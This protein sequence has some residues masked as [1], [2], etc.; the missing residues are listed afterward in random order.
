MG[1]SLDLD[2]LLM[3]GETG[4]LC[5]SVSE[6]KNLPLNGGQVKLLFWYF[7]EVEFSTI[8]MILDNIYLYTTLQYSQCPT[9]RAHVIS[10]THAGVFML[11]SLDPAVLSAPTAVY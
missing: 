7:K 3:W 10:Q 9:E 4:Y 8:L 2:N 11:F 6:Y 1:L 5:D